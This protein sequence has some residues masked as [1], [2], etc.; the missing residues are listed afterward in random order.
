MGC[1]IK[2]INPP[3]L[4]TF[5]TIDLAKGNNNW[6]ASISIFLFSCSS[7]KF[8]DTFTSPSGAAALPADVWIE[9]VAREKNDE[10]N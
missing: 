3:S 7:F 10:L 6:G 1:I 5:E 4:V 9:K 2:G 8:T